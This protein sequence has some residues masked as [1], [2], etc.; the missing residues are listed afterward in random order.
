MWRMRLR[1]IV[2]K[3]TTPNE[4]QTTA[5]AMSM[6]HSGSAYSLL[7]VMPSGIVTIAR[8]QPSCHPQNVK[9]ASPPNASR[10]WPVRWTM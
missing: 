1:A 5:T 9:L 4:T 3:N 7:C 10:V 8:T 6:N 2:A